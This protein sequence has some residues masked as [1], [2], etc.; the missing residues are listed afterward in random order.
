LL[1]SKSPLIKLTRPIRV[2]TVVC[3]QDIVNRMAENLSVALGDARTSV[4]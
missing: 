1:L 4:F 3:E 2:N